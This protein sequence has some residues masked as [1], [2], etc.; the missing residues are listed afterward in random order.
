M[1]VLKNNVSKIK[2]ENIYG[3]I[4]DWMIKKYIRDGTIKVVG[5]RKD[6]ASDVDQVSIDFHLGK[7]ILMPTMGRHVVIDTHKG[8]NSKMYEEI[9]LK[10]GDPFVI[11]PAQFFIGETMEDFTLPENIIGRL[12]GKS[13]L[14][15][16]GIVVHQ[17][18]ARFDPGWSGPAALE[19]RNNSDNDVVLYCGD[20][21]CAFVFE[22][23]M[24]VVEMPYQPKNQRYFGNKKLISMVHRD[25]K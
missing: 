4:P 8:V 1:N 24:S 9:F 3:T 16:L 2:T 19:I 12:E 21:I 20:K 6:W 13:S 23:L 15:R 11:R 25:Y 22:R 17:T 10:P 5:L 14:A 18:S 7:R